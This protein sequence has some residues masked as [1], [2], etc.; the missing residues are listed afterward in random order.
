MEYGVNKNSFNK[1][2]KDTLET[3]LKQQLWSTGRI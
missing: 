1:L 2:E 3:H